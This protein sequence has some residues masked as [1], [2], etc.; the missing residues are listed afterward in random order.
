MIEFSPEFTAFLAM[1]D[2]ELVAAA[3]DGSTVP[4]DGSSSISSTLLVAGHTYIVREGAGT[5]SLQQDAEKPVIDRADLGSVEKTLA[6]LI[7]PAVRRSLALPPEGFLPDIFTLAPGFTRVSTGS[8]MALTW[9][10]RGS[11]R[12]GERDV[13]RSV[14]A[15]E[16]ET[17]ES[18]HT[19]R[20]QYLHHP[21]EA[22]IESFTAAGP[23]ILT[24]DA[25]DAPRPFR[26]PER[27]HTWIAPAFDGTRV[28]RQCVFYNELSFG[29][30]ISVVNGGYR[31]DRRAERTSTYSRFQIWA[32]SM[33]VLQV[34]LVWMTRDARNVANRSGTG[35]LGA[36][37]TDLPNGFAIDP[38]GYTAVGDGTVGLR[39][40]GT[41]QAVLKAPAGDHDQTV[42]R[43]SHLIAMGLDSL[44]LEIADPQVL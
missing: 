22:I 13:E 26:L 1:A 7:G 39:R 32:A 43:L 23:G 28:S 8:G 29:L 6:M 41:L 33:E 4:S 40:N 36:D 42:T 16:G 5:Y 11:E 17:V 15:R 38:S 35:P 31:V 19:Y 44:E 9:N 21:L 24:D 37:L 34:Y 14:V 25:P 12:R 10:E 18:L 20:S 30:R 3:A 2:V 27:T